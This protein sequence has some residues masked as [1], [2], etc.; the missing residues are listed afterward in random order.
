MHSGGILNYKSPNTIVWNFYNIDFTC[1]GINFKVYKI[2][3][4]YI[5]NIQDN[6]Q[7]SIYKTFVCNY[8]FVHEIWTSITERGCENR[9]TPTY[10]V[11]ILLKG[12]FE[13]AYEK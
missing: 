5:L 9:E 10:D 12:I 8:M 1:H 6:Y 13:D 3:Y 7:N 2:Q 11:C 4:M